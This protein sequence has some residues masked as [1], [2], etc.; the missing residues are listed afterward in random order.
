MSIIVALLL[1]IIQGLTEFIPISSTAHLTI[2]GSL[3]GVIDPAHPE[4]WTAFMATIQLGTLAAVLAYFRDE[5]RRTVQHW[6]AENLGSGRRAFSQQSAESRLGWLVVIGTVPI[7]VVGLS[8]KDIIEGGLTKDLSVIAFSLIGVGLLLLVAERIATFTRST[9]DLG[10]IDA[11]AIGGAQC[12][13]LI[14]GSSRSGTTI[15]AALLRGMTREHA[16][17]FSFLLSIPAIF[18]AG[19]LEFY[20]Q[21][22]NI[23]WDDGGI[24]LTL[25]TLA[26]FISGYWS[27]AFLLNYLKTRTLA[28]F[29]AYRVALGAVILLTGCSEPA[30]RQEPIL[31]K[32]A[33]PAETLSAPSGVLTPVV[34]TT[35]TV[36]VKTSAGSFAIELYGRDAPKTV[37]NFLALVDKGY[38]NGILIHRVAKNFVIQMGDPT[39]KDSKAKADW[40]KGGETATGEMLPEELDKSLP[41]AQE[42]YRKGLVAMARKQTSGSGTSQFFVCLEQATN[43]PYTSTIFGN[44]I[45]GMDVVEKIGNSEVEA[46]PLGDTDGVPKKAIKISSIKRMKP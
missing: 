27:I 14:P 12:L 2:A 38:Y 17:R 1:G 30:A 39:T 29:V 23:T 44:V 9:S 28:S 3:F 42:G 11:L 32:I 33:P 45:D 26:A 18:A 34:E 4:K 43:L 10:L 31:E 24:Q 36:V 6:L 35:D 16:A 8:L 7:V 15:L 25:A 37:Q 22:G 40:G 13:A 5:I 20:E 19:V 21:A 41:S 46:G